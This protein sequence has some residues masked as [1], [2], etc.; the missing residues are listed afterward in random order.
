MVKSLANYF[1]FSTIVIGKFDHFYF[2]NYSEK[3]VGHISKEWLGLAVW[4]IKEIPESGINLVFG[5]MRG[6]EK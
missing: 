1:E 3:L 2:I 4:L 5:S 6:N